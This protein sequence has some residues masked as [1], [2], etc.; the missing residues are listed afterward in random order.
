VRG[1]HARTQ[2]LV[3]IDPF[4]PKVRIH[5][6]PEVPGIE[7]NYGVGVKKVRAIVVAAQGCAASPGPGTVT[8]EVIIGGIASTLGA[9]MVPDGTHLNF[10]ITVFVE[11]TAESQP[12][13]V[14]YQDTEHVMVDP[15][16][17][18]DPS[19]VT[20]GGVGVAGA[21]EHGVEVTKVIGDIVFLR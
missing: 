16:I 8:P 20:S 19:S 15:G 7:E 14:Q 2:I 1:E 17:D 21:D 4:L 12:V 5:K 13:G 18:I 11:V 9:V 3:A 6:Q 10:L